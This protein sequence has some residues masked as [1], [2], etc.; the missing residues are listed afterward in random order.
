[1]PQNIV[2]VTGS[3]RANGNSEMLADAFIEGA[4]ESGN[5][6]TKFNAGRMNIQGCLD[7][8]FCFAHDGECFRKDDMQIIDKALHK[9]DMLVL[10][11]P[12]YWYGLTSQIKAMIDRMFASS[13]KPYPLT[14]MALLLVYGDTDNKVAAP[15]IAHF[16]AISFYMGWENK[17]IVTQAGVKSPGEIKR[18]KSLA[19]AREL[20]KSIQ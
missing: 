14:S 16:E 20:G 3:P 9:A 18:K 2:V 4:K 5:T 8:K 19:E 13:V 11:S 7:C 10:A 15:A 1:M 17:G 12:V 6:V